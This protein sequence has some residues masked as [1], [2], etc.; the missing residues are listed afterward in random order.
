[1]D[2]SSLFHEP[3]ADLGDTEE[4]LRG[5][6]APRGAALGAAAGVTSQFLEDA[7]QYHQRYFD[8]SYWASV[9]GRALE[10]I[11][12]GFKPTTVL[13]IGS[14]SGNSV[15]P[16]AQRF[17]DARIVATDVSPQLLSILRDFIDARP[18]KERFALVCVDATQARYREG[19]I[20]LAVGAAILHHLLEPERVLE[21][22]HTALVPGG[23]AIFFE[24]FQAGNLL[25]ALA[26]QRILGHATIVER[27]SPGMRMLERIVVDY[28]ARV[29]PR[30]DPRYDSL[31]DKWMFT[32]SYFDRLA[33]AQ[34]WAEV[35]TYAMHD[36]PDRLQNQAA[37]HL[38]LGAGLSREALPAWAWGML[39]ETDAALSEDLRQELAQEAAILLRKPR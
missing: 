28:F 6:C 15:F 2:P 23:W 3:L 35:V 13:D 12:N 17:P 21:A 26:Y 33:Q 14:G 8:T 7:A 18:D 36:E 25:L 1:M 11:G 16:M 24:P 30:G 19:S 37:V 9:I 5:I 29:A 4:R 39:E 22:C 38:R 32:R 34:G 27:E 20:D 31:D 10:R